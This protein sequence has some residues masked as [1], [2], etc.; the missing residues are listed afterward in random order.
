MEEYNYFCKPN[1]ASVEEALHV[2]ME[3]R[4]FQN[5]VQENSET[6]RLHINNNVEIKKEEKLEDAY[7]KIQKCLIH[8]PLP[9]LKEV[10]DII[11]VNEP[12]RQSQNNSFSDKYTNTEDNHSDDITILYDHCSETRQ[13]QFI[14]VERYIYRDTITNFNNHYI[15]KLRIHL[16]RSF[17]QISIPTREIRE[18]QNVIEADADIEEVNVEFQSTID[19]LKKN[20][21]K[22]VEGNISTNFVPQFYTEIKIKELLR[23]CG[24]SK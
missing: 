4:R 15:D 7:E 22:E 16:S 1:S 10:E 18:R 5:S 14:N 12:K 24:H 9:E 19:F 20:I 3:K 23:S 8:L 11:T 6:I 21:V 17:H 2:L 13:N